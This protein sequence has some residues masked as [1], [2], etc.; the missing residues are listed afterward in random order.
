MDSLNTS[1]Q[2]PSC[3][4]KLSKTSNTSV[5]KTRNFIPGQSRLPVPYRDVKTNTGK[6]MCI[7]KNLFEKENIKPRTSSFQEDGYT[8]AYLEKEKQK[9]LEYLHSPK[10]AISSPVKGGVL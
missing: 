8:L 7:R 1:K 5:S 4:P 3:I 10:K 9:K 2:K 6:K